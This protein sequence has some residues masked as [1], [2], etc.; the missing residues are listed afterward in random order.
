T[1]CSITCFLV[2]GWLDRNSLGL[3][4]PMR[5]VFA[6]IFIGIGS[7]VFLWA[8]RTLSLST[9]L[10]VQG[11]LITEGPYR[12]SRN[13][14]YVAMVVFFSGMLL[15]FNSVFALITGSIGILWFL[16]LP[17]VEEPWLQAQFVDEYREYCAQIPRFI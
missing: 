2:I 1:E 5:F 14:Q 12:Y 3:I 8:L 11:K 15:L 7:I 6:L 9:S 10:G 4:H 16:L 17:F 13:P